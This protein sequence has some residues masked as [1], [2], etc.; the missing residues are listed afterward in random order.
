MHPV[1]SSPT[2]ALSSPM[3]RALELAWEAFCSGSFPVGAVIVDAAGNV[4]AEGR[5]RMG[6]SDAPPGRLRGTG[7]AH[8]EVDALSQLRFGDYAGHVL[9]TTL[10]PCLMCRSAI[11]MAHVGTV[12]YLAA[13]ALC[14]GLHRI[15]ELNGHASRRYPTMHRVHHDEAPIAARFASVLPMAVLLLFGPEGDTASHYREHASIEAAM[16]E[17][18][19]AEQLWP[20]RALDLDGAIE[21]LLPILEA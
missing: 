13:D 14:D 19:V 9:H 10:E 21:S 12:R 11:T 8:A 3:R 17:R 2:D 20:D 15:P 4:V 7:I 18:L 6:E 5:N 16:A 1:T